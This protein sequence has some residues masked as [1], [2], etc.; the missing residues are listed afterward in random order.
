MKSQCR[1]NNNVNM[2]MEEQIA[3]EREARRATTCSRVIYP[4][5]R[6][7]VSK[8]WSRS[9]VGMGRSDHPH[10]ILSRIVSYNFR[11]VLWT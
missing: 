5:E 4:R 11:E 7:G 6:A 10:V 8:P 3:K 2:P 1:L 9:S